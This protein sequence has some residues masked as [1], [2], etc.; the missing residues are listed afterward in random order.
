MPY[1]LQDWENHQWS[2]EN[3]RLEEMMDDEE[4]TLEEYTEDDFWAI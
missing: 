2:K 3:K 4:E 1:T